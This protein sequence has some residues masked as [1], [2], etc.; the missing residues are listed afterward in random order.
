MRTEPTGQCGTWQAL[1][2]LKG[3]GGR[4]YPTSLSSSAPKLP[5]L[6]PTDLREGA[7]GLWSVDAEGPSGRR[8]EGKQENQPVAAV[9]PARNSDLASRTSASLSPP[10]TVQEFVLNL[11]WIILLPSRKLYTNVF[12]Y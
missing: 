5:V 9:H 3:G 12:I 6:P 10:S 4:W 8:S 7:K 11:M 2:G 1:E